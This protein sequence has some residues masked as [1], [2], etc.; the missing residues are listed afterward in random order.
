VG[1]RIKSSSKNGRELKRFGWAHFGQGGAEDRRKKGKQGPGHREKKGMK[2]ENE[3]AK[4]RHT[5][6]LLREVIRRR[7]RVGM[8]GGT[9][10]GS[11]SGKDARANLIQQ[12]LGEGIAGRSECNKN[13]ITARSSNG[14]N[15]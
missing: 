15:V 4:S 10:T 7:N 14:V 5:V 2:T 9:E 8:G 13:F 1:G 6:S 3:L 11:I 12:S